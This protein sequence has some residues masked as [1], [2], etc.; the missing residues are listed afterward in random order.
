MVAG[1]STGANEAA[2]IRRSIDRKTLKLST[3]VGACA[4]FVTALVWT[5]SRFSLLADAKRVNS[6]SLSDVTCSN[7]TCDTM[8]LSTRWDDPPADYIIDSRTGYFIMAPDISI[9]GSY[10]LPA[11]DYCDIEF[12]RRF[13]RPASLTTPGGERWRLY[14]REIVEDGRRLE[15][16]VGYALQAPW[17]L[18]ETPDTQ[19]EL[20]DRALKREADLVAMARHGPK[21]PE[22]SR[23]TGL[24]ADG[25][26]LVD[27]E[28]SRIIESL[29]L[30]MFLPKYVPLPKPGLGVHVHD[31]VLSLSL[32]ST[33]KRIW[34]ISLIQVGPLL[35]IVGSLVGAFLVLTCITYG[36]LA[37]FFQDRLAMAATHFPTL[38]EALRSGEGE[39]IEFKRGLR[40]DPDSF[41][42]ADE[43]LLKT[44]AAFANT[45]GG[46]I[47]VGVD[48]RGHVK[49]LEMEK[50]RFERKVHE[51]VRNRIRP[52]PPVRVEFEEI[53]GSV[54][55]KIMVAR[56][57]DPVYMLSGTIYLRDGSSDIRAQ[58]EDLHRLY[59]QYGF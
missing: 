40:P 55:G 33:D 46:V 32:V 14:S 27:A 30:P 49:G 18:L 9:S 34:A 21:D 10:R 20:V 44:V 50:D 36:V 51:L 47:F 23:R 26:V 41:S 3:F 17:R 7:T 35:T 53:H 37:R 24:R 15:V 48:D 1:G 29:F 5:I 58:P 31:G 8:R 12:I 2:S 19:L 4:V 22:R 43:E 54:V 59:L 16:M 39:S 6:R 42:P 45:G 28:T 11:V 57:P 38:R 52:R 25:F 56:G 13:R